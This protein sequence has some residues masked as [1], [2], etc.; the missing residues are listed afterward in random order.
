MWG[1][2]QNDDR[3]QRDTS[4]NRYMIRIILIGDYINNDDDDDDY[5]K[6]NGIDKNE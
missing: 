5:Y 2:G 1:G 6:N 3:G 4:Y